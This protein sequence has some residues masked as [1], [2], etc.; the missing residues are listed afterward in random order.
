MNTRHHHKQRTITSFFFNINNDV[1]YDLL[2]AALD[3]ELTIVTAESM[4]FFLSTVESILERRRSLKEPVKQSEFEACDD[5]LSIYYNNVRGITNK[6][7]ISMRIE[8]CPFKV[9][10]FT[11]TWLDELQPNH[12]YLPSCFDVHRSDRSSALAVLAVLLFS[13]ARPFAA[14]S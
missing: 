14:G 10:C 3:F 2:Q 7:F 6:K 8:T 11:E 13:S 4:D 5:R 1:E 12:L 9:L